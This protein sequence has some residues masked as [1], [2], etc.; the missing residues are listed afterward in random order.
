MLC[1]QGSAQKQ[2]VA[3]L[4]PHLCGLSDFGGGRNAV[5]AAP[6][7]AGA[8]PAAV[9]GG[10]GAG[11]AA[12]PSWN[13]GRKS[14][15]R[16]GSRAAAKGGGGARSFG[17]DPPSVSLAALWRFCWRRTLSAG[18]PADARFLPLPGSVRLSRSWATGEGADSASWS[19]GSLGLYTA[20]E[21]DPRQGLR[22]LH[23]G[24]FHAPC[25]GS[26]ILWGAQTL[27]P[28][29]HPLAASQLSTW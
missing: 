10:L 18:P 23:C 14:G 15:D 17:C 1:V 24:P 28:S 12:A 19:P 29:P 20:Q 21:K 9:A 2:D 7:S 3:P 22:C 13:E 27:S 8:W 25:P 4:P 11:S 26:P 16:S 6:P 5:V